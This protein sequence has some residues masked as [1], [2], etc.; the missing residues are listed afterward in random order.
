MKSAQSKMLLVFLVIYW[1]TIFVLTHIP[2]KHMNLLATQLTFSDKILHFFA[3]F[4]L[5]VLLWTSLNPG[6]K[7]DWRKARVWLFLAVIVWYG[8]FDEWLQAYTQRGCSAYDFLA[9]LAGATTAFIL[10]SIFSFKSGLKHKVGKESN[11]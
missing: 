1:A 6:T 5:S 2:A 9:D 11:S 8:A 10:L 7:V 3:Y 4:L